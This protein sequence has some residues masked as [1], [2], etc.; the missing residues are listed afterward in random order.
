MSAEGPRRALRVAVALA[1]TAASVVVLARVDRAA[2]LRALSETHPLGLAAALALRVAQV[3]F[4][5]L[6]W[7]LLLRPADVS[8]RLGF[9]LIARTSLYSAV[10]GARAGDLLRAHALV[11]EADVPLGLA[12]GVTVLEKALSVA[13]L[14]AILGVTAALSPLPPWVRAASASLAAVGVA[15][16]LALRVAGLVGGRFAVLRDAS[17]A[18]PR[19][20]F[21]RMAASTCS[22]TADW[23]A[24]IGAHLTLLRACG[25]DV[26]AAAAVLMQLSINAATSVPSA[27]LHLGAFEL[28]V[29]W[30]LQALGAPTPRALGYAF[31]LHAVELAAPLLAAAVALVARRRERSCA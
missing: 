11:D 16:V 18:L 27:P 24:G 5:A 29:V 8:Y 25:V 3:A 20:D 1:V 17:N 13:T 31:A 12:L 15:A 28:S 19:N 30:V 23:L 21:S 10:V 26:S 2:A 9:A 4:R 14:L 7:T 22:V 6:T